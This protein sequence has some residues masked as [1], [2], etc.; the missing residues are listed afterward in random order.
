MATPICNNNCFCCNNDCAFKHFLPDSKERKIASKIRDNMMLPK[1]EIPC[2][3]R[4]AN[5]IYG[6]FCKNDKCGYKHSGYDIHAR[7]MYIDEYELKKATQKSENI[8]EKPI[9]TIKPVSFKTSNKFDMLEVE[10]EVEKPIVVI[11]TKRSWA[12]IMDC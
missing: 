8:N 3:T 10:V 7:R 12:D 4:R 9:M 2:E 11:E 1:K 6:I 5:C